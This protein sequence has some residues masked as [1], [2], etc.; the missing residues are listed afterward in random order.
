MEADV[1]DAEL[2]EP[3]PN[4]TRVITGNIR[5][6]RR[7]IQLLAR[8]QAAQAQQVAEIPAVVPW[9]GWLVQQL[10]RAGFQ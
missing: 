3:Q 9:S 1:V 6:G 5:L 4:A 10:D 2:R 8:Q 7:V